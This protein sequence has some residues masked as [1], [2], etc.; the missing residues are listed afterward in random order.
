M[1]VIGERISSLIEETK[2]VD[3]SNLVSTGFFSTLKSL[4][5]NPVQNF[6]EKKK[7]VDAVITKIKA[8]L[9]G[10]RAWLLSENE[11]LELAYQDNFTSLSVY[12]NTMLEGMSYLK[13]LEEV[14]L[15]ELQAR[16][17]ASNDERDLM[18]I[19]EL[20]LYSSR[21]EKRLSRIYAARAIVLRQ[22]P[23]IRNMQSIN[24]T[25]AETI[26]DLIHTALP[27]WIEQM[28]LFVSQLATAKTIK[29]E[30]LVK[31]M[32]NKTMQENAE[33]MHKNSV[34]AAIS[35]NGDII[36]IAT[37]QSINEH[38]ISGL[39]ETKE[40]NRKGSVDRRNNV[41]AI[42]KMNEELALALSDI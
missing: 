12:D 40:I 33:L 34:D 26:D 17:T 9:E 22:G 14:V 41:Q 11:R 31:D 1:D 10:D 27:V 6:I 25:H 24:S 5:S 35:S 39:K 18:L 30:T 23:Q 32:I 4:V 15:P 29:N 20:S 13:N 7:T 21:L 16:Y 3:A 37:I 2:K 38:L 8:G 36:S 19:N 42:T 28:S